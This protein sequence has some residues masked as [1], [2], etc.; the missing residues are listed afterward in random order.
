MDMILNIIPWIDFRNANNPDYSDPLKSILAT[1][2]HQA[3][4]SIYPVQMYKGDNPCW[5]ILMHLLLLKNAKRA[6]KQ[7]L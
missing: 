6:N 4:N 3:R 2:V 5:P 7:N 1:S